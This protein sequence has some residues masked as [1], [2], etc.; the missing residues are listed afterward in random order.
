LRKSREV[1]SPSRERDGF[2]NHVWQYLTHVVQLDFDFP[3]TLHPKVLFKKL[4]AIQ[5]SDESVA[6]LAAGYN[7]ESHRTVLSKRLSPFWNDS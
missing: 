6:L 2:S 1:T 4:I 5:A 3:Y 7:H